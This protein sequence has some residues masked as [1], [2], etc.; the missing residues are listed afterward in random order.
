MLFHT[1][2]MHLKQSIDA[3]LYLKSYKTDYLLRH[4]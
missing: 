1:E 3:S 4:V 2:N